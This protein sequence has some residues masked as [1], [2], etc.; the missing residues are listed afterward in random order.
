MI[1]EY[2]ELNV[3]DWVQAYHGEN[4]YYLSNPLNILLIPI[5]LISLYFRTKQ[6]DIS[7][8]QKDGWWS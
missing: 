8:G 3:V 5:G 2:F 7:G 6:L 1:R 4:P